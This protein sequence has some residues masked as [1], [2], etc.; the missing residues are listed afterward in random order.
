MK[1]I[2]IIDVIG[3]RNE[4]ATLFKGVGVELG[5]ERAVFSK[6]IIKYADKLFLIDPWKAYRGYREHVSQDKLDGFFKEAQER[7]LGKNCEF[8]RKFSLDAVNDFEDNSL[9]FVYIDANHSYE[10]VKADIEAWTKKVKVGGIV[11]GHDYIRR[12]GQA[13]IFGVVD[14]VNEL[15]ETVTIWRGDRSPSWSFIKQ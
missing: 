4:L 2:K 14:A 9:D 11:S 12:K 5:V 6:E 1:E 7:M 15:K 8:I 13:H 10:N 3:G